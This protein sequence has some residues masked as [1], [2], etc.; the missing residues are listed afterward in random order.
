MTTI[1]PMK[2]KRWFIFLGVLVLGGGFWY[3]KKSSVTPNY[4]TI[5]VIRGDVTETVSASVS[6]V[7]SEEIDLNFEIPGRIKSIAVEEGQKVAAGETL[8]TLESATLE[9][10]VARA[11]AALEQAK[12]GASMNDNT[13]REARES[14]K[15]LKSYYETVKEAEDQKVS[16]SDAAYEN[17]KDYEDD[18]ESYYNQVVSDSGASSSTAKSAKLTLTAAT[19][20]R[21]AADEARDTAQ[22]NRES[23]I[24]YAKN[25]WDA[26]QEKTQTLES[27]AQ[28]TIE[29]SAI[30]SAEATY[31]IAIASAKKAD[32]TA[33]VNGLV[34][35]VNFSKGEVVGSAVSNPFGKLLSYDLLLEAKV[36]ESDITKVKLGQSANISFDAFDSK[37]VLPAEVIE[38]KP[39]ATIIQ[40][41]VYY[42]VKLRLTSVDARLKPGMSGDSDIH[43]DERRDVIEIPSRLLREENGKQFAKVLTSNGT[44]EDREVT[45]GLRGDDGQIEIRSGLSE[46]EKVV[47]STP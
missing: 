7:A 41:V 22:K 44:A 19:N 39:D 45:T 8:A 14:E 21:K 37:D 28:T 30:Q 9:G 42:V 11:R 16:A 6:L 33:P 2:F 13:L 38:I 4:E 29:T 35:K 5:P 1:S 46:G 27:A 34:T 26:A 47:S 15:N 43:I 23:S 25:S 31:A 3:W 20:A 40:D 36:P 32:I 12:A 18:A 17:A 24:R 10:E